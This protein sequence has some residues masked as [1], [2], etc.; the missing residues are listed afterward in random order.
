MLWYILLYN[1]LLTSSKG[2]I[3]FDADINVSTYSNPVGVGNEDVISGN[4]NNAPPGVIPKN[5]VYKSSLEKLF[6]YNLTPKSFIASDTKS[7]DTP[8]SNLLSALYF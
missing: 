3:S 4:G 1:D 5:A 7:L 6:W 2:I 8:K